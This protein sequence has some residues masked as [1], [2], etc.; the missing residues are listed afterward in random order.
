[1]TS[2]RLPTTPVVEIFAGGGQQSPSQDLNVHEI[3]LARPASLFVGKVGDSTF[4]GRGDIYIVDA[5]L[6][7]LLQIAQDDTIVRLTSGMDDPHGISGLDGGMAGYVPAFADTGNNRIVEQSS[8]ANPA[9]LLG[10][11]AGLDSPLGV[12]AGYDALYVADTGNQRILFAPHLL[13]SGNPDIA[14]VVGTGTDGFAGDGGQPQDAEL[15][16]PSALAYDLADY[17]LLIADSGNHRVRSASLGGGTIETIAGNGETTALPFDPTLSATATPLS[18]ISA[19]AVDSIGSVYFP[20]RW[21]DVGETVMRLD[22][23]GTFTRI[24]GGGASTVAGVA[25]LDFQ[26]PDVLAL[27]LNQFDGSL[28]IGAADGVVY[29]VADVG[30]FTGN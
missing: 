27:E 20:V 9:I 2:S 8:D 6:G 19:L 22:A 7:E 16:N 29:R 4:V 24:V 15:S 1:M 28:L 25:A 30:P 18:E 11:E 14:T 21:S 10:K 17:R 5:G 3:A 12:A 26:L 13:D 23:Y